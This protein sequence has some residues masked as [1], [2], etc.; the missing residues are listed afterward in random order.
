M[1]FVCLQNSN[2]VEI[3][4]DSETN[5]EVYESLSQ[6]YQEGLEEKMKGSEIVFDNVD[7]LY[8]KLHKISL[9]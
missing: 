6:R 4:I 7:S 1:R 2:N 8:Y 3:L 5:K 9:K